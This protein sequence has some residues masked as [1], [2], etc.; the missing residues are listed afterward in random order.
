MFELTNIID[1]G[2]TIV[3]IVVAMPLMVLTI[4]CFLGV[5]LPKKQTPSSYATNKTARSG[6]CV[7]VPAHN[8]EKGIVESLDSMV[9]ALGQDD[10]L[11]VVADNCTDQTVELVRDFASDLKKHDADGLGRLPDLQLLVRHD[12]E[13]RGKDYALRFAFDQLQV[14]HRNQLKTVVIV[15]AD[16]Q[17][18]R[19][20]FEHLVSQVENSQRPA[21][22]VYL[23]HHPDTV[24]MTPRRAI[25]E[26]AFTLKNL[27]RPVGLSRIGGA[28]T[29]FGS[30]MAFPIDCI[31]SM[32]GPGGHLVE[33]MRWT[34]DMILAGK[35]VQFCHE[36][37]VE[38]EFPTTMEAAQSQRRRWEHG[39]L[40][41]IL[42]Q[43]PRLLGH[44]MKIPLR[45]TLL[46]ALDLMIPP[47][48]LLM[49]ISIA[50][51]ATLLISAALGASFVPFLLL[52]L[53]VSLAMTSLFIAWLR[54]KPD[55]VMHSM[56][57]SFPYY[58][59]RK[60][61]LYVGFLLRPQRTWVRTDRT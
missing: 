37:I 39:H 43:T 35:P 34:Y 15:D 21:Q 11:V 20:A 50:V 14:E 49:V 55:R 51:L 40:E 53:S 8:E 23:M 16:C 1:A 48:S 56:I 3:A 9:A 6:A 2:L 10:R 32:T 31:K 59:I 25:S 52:G 30:G 58:A 12:D 29:L 54:F 33:D 26:F 17:V 27:V 47:L 5:S 36:A 61:P 19:D 22:A 28:C 4:E 13:H 38:A 7:V 44:F 42:T 18:R 46:A 45:G 41:L 24:R 60:L 57:F